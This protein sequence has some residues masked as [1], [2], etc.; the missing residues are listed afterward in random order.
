MSWLSAAGW[1]PEPLSN[2][3]AYLAVA[4][5]AEVMLVAYGVSSVVTGLGREAFGMRQVLTGMLAD[6]ARRRAS[7][8]DDGGARGRLGGGGAGIRSGAGR[9][10]GA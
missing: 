5:T 1:L 7:P 4:A 3:L 6:R 9:V 8:A 10:V 2:P